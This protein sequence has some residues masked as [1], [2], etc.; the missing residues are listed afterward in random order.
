MGKSQEDDVDII[1]SE[2]PFTMT[3][4]QLKRATSLNEH[5]NISIAQLEYELTSEREKFSSLF[6][7]V[8]KLTKEKEEMAKNHSRELEKWQKEVKKIQSAKT[9]LENELE[10]LQ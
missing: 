4:S 9:I 6:N 2:S 1:E 3:P 10:T 5:N 8:D 7:D